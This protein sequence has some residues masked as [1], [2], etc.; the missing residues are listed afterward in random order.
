MAYFDMFMVSLQKIA[1]QHPLVVILDEF[2]C[3]CSLREEVVSRSAIISR[4]RSHSQHGYGIH[5]ILSGGGLSSQLTSQCDIAS[6]FNISHYERLGCLER[7]A[8]HQLIKDGLSKVGNIT[9]PAIELLLDI[10][11]GHPFYLQLLCSMLFDQAKENKTI[12]T[13]DAVTQ[14]I[15]VWLNEADTSRFQHFWEGQNIGGGQRNKL[16]LSAI[17]ELSANNNEVEYDRLAGAANIISSERDLFQSLQ[18]LV[19]LGVLEREHSNYAIKVR[20][21]SRWLREHLPLKLVIKE[22]SEV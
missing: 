10:T 1:K 20:L 9:E 11:A 16:I 13:A 14:S 15:R 12:I 4:L 2:Q 22:V 5:F 19:D 8:A 18:D 17:A 7:K 6:L 3:L 21:F